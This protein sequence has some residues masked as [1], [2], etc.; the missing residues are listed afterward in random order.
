MG[1]E[2]CIRDRITGNPIIPEDQKDQGTA[3]ID[4]L[5][6][7]EDSKTDI[8]NVSIIFS[9]GKFFKYAGSL[10]VFPRLPILKR[11]MTN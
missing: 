10:F 5:A 8:L 7:W 6:S 1:S 9:K 3:K 11:Q 4:P 2:M